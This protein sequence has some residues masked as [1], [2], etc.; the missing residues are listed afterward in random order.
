[1]EN[2]K[3]RVKAGDMLHDWCAATSGVPQGTIVGSVM[4]LV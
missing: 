1:M 4:I 2:R 3:Q